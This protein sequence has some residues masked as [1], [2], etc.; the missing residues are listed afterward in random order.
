MKPNHRVYAGEEAV[1][2]ALLLERR[3]AVVAGGDV[4]GVQSTSTV[5]I[6]PWKAR[7]LARKQKKG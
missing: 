4:T 2:A 1:N 5:A 3:T 6:P 7:L